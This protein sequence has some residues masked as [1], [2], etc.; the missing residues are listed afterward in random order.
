M[1]RSSLVIAGLIFV[2]SA[3]SAKVTRELASKIAVSYLSGLGNKHFVFKD[4][5]E[6]NNENY[7]TQYII[8]LSPEGW[9][10]IAA[11]D[12][13]KP[14]IA[15]SK[16]GNFTLDSNISEDVKRWING[17][18]DQISSVINDNLKSKS[19][20]WDKLQHDGQGS[21]TSGQNSVAPILDIEWDQVAGWNNL[22]PVDD[23]GPGGHT[24][25]GCVALA[26]AQAM[27]NVKLEAPLS[28]AH[29]YVHDIYGAIS[30]VFESKEP[31]D[32]GA[33][34]KNKP[35]IE[36]QRLLYYCAVAIS[37]D[38]GAKGSAASPVNIIGALKEYF[39]Y[40]ADLKYYERYD[41][42]DQ[43]WKNL[44]KSDLDK[45]NV[46]V[47]SGTD[48]IG[49]SFNIDGYDNNDYFHVNW[50][51]NGKYNGYYSIDNLNPSGYR[52]DN[53]QSVIVGIADTYFGPTDITLS[54]EE[55]YEKIPAGSFVGKVE[56]K[57]NSAVDTFIYQL[58][59]GLDFLSGVKE[60]AFYI[61]NDS[62]KTKYI[63]DASIKNEYVLNI[64]VKDQQ[65]Y[66]FSKAF[67]IDIITKNST[68][69]S[70]QMI[71]SDR[72]NVYFNKKLNGLVLRSIVKN[73][74]I[75][76]ELFDMNGTKVM[77][78]QITEKNTII[79][80][81]HLSKGIYLVHLSIGDNSFY[82]KILIN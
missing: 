29:R 7:P 32:W 49:H 54:S 39:G 75:D 33:M 35:N 8:N 82:K 47:Y 21:L 52:F 24:R 42:E 74:K 3:F 50:G 27:Y 79:N 28:G 26:M 51:W 53:N 45:G 15:Y 2:F 57:D 30:I 14:V 62:L 48:E 17:Y 59:G 22:C 34:A 81:D 10:I 6:I 44:I 20:E 25:I 46:L 72:F 56:V 12:N 40:S 78:E 77:D 16:K 1:K 36:N 18:S 68:S 31:F 23:D 55:V 43:D 19:S 67:I 63:F 70:K 76:F 11:D 66:N 80:V 58:D 60:T 65:G 61:E 41:F 4:I 9:V 13:I 37:T 71:N 64:H 69:V 73:C 5:T 38:F